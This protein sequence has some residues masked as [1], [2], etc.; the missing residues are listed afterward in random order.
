MCADLFKKDVDLF[1]TEVPHLY[2]GY[3]T[4]GCAWEALITERSAGQQ[5]SPDCITEAR[6]LL[7]N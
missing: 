2:L 7:S 6:E 5:N 3:T 4:L 1:F